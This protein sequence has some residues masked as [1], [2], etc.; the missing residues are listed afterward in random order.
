LFERRKAAYQCKI[1]S[2]SDDGLKNQ[3]VNGN[4]VPKIEHSPIRPNDDFDIMFQSC[5]AI[6]TTDFSSQTP[7][8]FSSNTPKRQKL[9][10]EVKTQK[11]EIIHLKKTIK[12]LN[13]QLSKYE[14]EE[15]FLKLSKKYL[16]P[17]VFAIVK[18]QIKNKK[19]SL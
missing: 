19:K 11:K 3:C 6:S 12:K 15:N 14:T 9:V 1:A 16:S 4:L 17:G 2:K 7:R 5:F 18:S 10:V 8:S 13:R